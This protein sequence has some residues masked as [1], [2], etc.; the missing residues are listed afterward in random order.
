MF[1]YPDTFLVVGLTT[2]VKRSHTKINLQNWSTECYLQESA[3]KTVISGADPE[4]QKRE[5]C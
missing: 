5:G 3:M 2:L 4:F 1:M